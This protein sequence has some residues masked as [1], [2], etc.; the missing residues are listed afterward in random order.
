MQEMN[1]VLSNQT[2]GIVTNIQNFSIHDGP[3]VR[4]TVFLK[5]CPLKCQWCANPETW[6]GTDGDSY[7]ADALVDKVMQQSIF[8]RNT[9]GGVTFSGGEPTVQ[10]LFLNEVV[11]K[12]YRLGVDMTIETCGYFD[13]EL[14]KTIVM[15]MDLVYFDLKH[16]DNFRHLDLCG[17]ENKLIL[18]NLKRC[19][20]E[21]SKLIV[22][23]P[24]IDPVNSDL[25]TIALTVDYIAKNLP[26]V[27]VELL[28]YHQF[29]DKKYDLLGTERPSRN[30][31]APSNA[32]FDAVFDI[33]K[34]KGVR[35]FMTHSDSHSVQD[36]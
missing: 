27:S 23:M 19:Y 2:K 34:S 26:D 6:Q 16:I 30:F 21:A 29:G 28:P 8:F 1:T 35:C 24:L 4:T 12:L 31:K 33:F 18:E 9:G 13:W 15:R 14:A 7:T 10:Y 22:R 5:G 32:H 36:N 20:K 25:E 11:D 17:V 3:G